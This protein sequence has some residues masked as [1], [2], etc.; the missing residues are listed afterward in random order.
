MIPIRCGLGLHVVM[1]EIF[2]NVTETLNRAQLW[3][4]LNWKSLDYVR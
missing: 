4:K 2:Y 1:C 3:Y